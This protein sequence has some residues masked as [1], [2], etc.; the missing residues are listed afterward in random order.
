MTTNLEGAQAAGAPVW[1]RWVSLLLEPANV[2]SVTVVTMGVST[3]LPE[4][5][6]GAGI[7]YGAAA[8]LLCAL[9]PAGLVQ[10]LARRGVLESRWVRPR[11]QR[12]ITL[13]GVVVLEVGAVGTLYLL[14]APELLIAMLSACVVG[15]IALTA[16]TPWVRASI[17]V[18]ALTVIAGVMTQVVP[19][20]TIGLLVLAAIV[21]AAR[22][23][24][25]EH[26][27]IEVATGF[28]WGFAVGALAAWP[29]LG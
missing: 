23:V 14:E 12:F 11:T 15:V 20:L 19:Q 29:L 25:R 7:A 18:G 2:V 16:V 8:F 27:P 13:A 28:A 1:A 3:A 21:A 22:L 26:T 4:R 5:G 17:H 9:I 24:Q 10:V 6:L